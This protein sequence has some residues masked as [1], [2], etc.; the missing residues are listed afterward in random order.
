MQELKEQVLSNMTGVD[1]RQDGA[2]RA[3]RQILYMISGEDFE[4]IDKEEMEEFL[5]DN[6]EKEMQDYS[7]YVRKDR[8]DAAGEYK[9]WS[10]WF[11]NQYSDKR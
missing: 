10:D 11:K 9:K 8:L 1:W 2:E 4:P 6:V 5:E 3:R 7:R